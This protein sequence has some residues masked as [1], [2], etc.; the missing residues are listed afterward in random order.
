[1][2]FF[3]MLN[4]F[5]S[6]ANTFNLDQSQK[7]SCGKELNIQSLKQSVGFFFKFLQFNALR[8]KS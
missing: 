8:R 1:M 3:L 4:F 6:S 7:L 2:F 5:L